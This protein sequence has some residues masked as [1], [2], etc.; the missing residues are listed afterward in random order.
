M[1]CSCGHVNAVAAFCA[2]CGLRLAAIA[3]PKSLVGTVAAVGIAVGFVAGYLTADARIPVAHAEISDAATPRSRRPLQ[4]SHPDEVEHERQ[5]RAI[6]D[7]RTIAT[8][9][10]SYSID[11]NFYTIQPSRASVARIARYFEPTYIKVVPRVDPWGTE[12]DYRSDHGGTLYQIRSL[13]SDRSESGSSGPTTSFA[14]DIILER[15][16]FVAWPEG[17]QN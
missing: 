5:R 10:E 15:G 7:I 6:S 17:A 11:N 8:A 2:Q 4:A 13:G 3:W 1:K 12:Y 14:D 9:V 16:S